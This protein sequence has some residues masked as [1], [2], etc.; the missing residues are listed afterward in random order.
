M[1]H[2]ML[3]EFTE[4]KDKRTHCV[5]VFD[6]AGSSCSGVRRRYVSLELCSAWL[7]PEVLLTHLS[8]FRLCLASLWLSSGGW[9]RF[10]LQPT[11]EPGT[12]KHLQIASTHLSKT[13]RSVC[14]WEGRAQIPWTLFLY[15]T[16]QH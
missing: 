7:L 3:P 10:A 13:R 11:S 16:G 5:L 15:S 2:E 12:H 8:S 6:G 1:I 9:D 14:C 4:W